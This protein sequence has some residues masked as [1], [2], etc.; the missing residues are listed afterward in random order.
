MTEIEKAIKIVAATSGSVPENWIKK[1][2]VLHRT[3]GFNAQ[4]LA[5]KYLGSVQDASD[6]SEAERIAAEIGGEV[7][8]HTVLYAVYRDGEWSAYQQA[9]SDYEERLSADLQE[10][11]E[12][13]ERV[14]SSDASRWR[15]WEW[16]TVGPYSGATIWW[17]EDEG[18]APIG[19]GMDCDNA[20]GQY[21]GLYGKPIAEPDRPIRPDPIWTSK[22][23]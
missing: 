1:W 6:H 10:M 17:Y 19:H 5:D 21:S 15:R 7:V 12:E 23:D 13:I 8:D 20:T 14:P 18:V 16:Q 22:E 4:E 2:K 9:L 11:P 3:F